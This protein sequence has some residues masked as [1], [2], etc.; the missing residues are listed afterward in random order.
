MKRSSPANR[1]TFKIETFKIQ[2]FREDA[3]LSQVVSVQMLK[4]G[5]AKTTTAYLLGLFAAQQGLKVLWVDL[6]QQ[7]NLTHACGVNADEKPVFV[8]VLEKK[9]SFEKAVVRLHENLSLFPSNLNN[10]IV[11]RVLLNS[12]RNWSVVVKQA[13]DG[14]RHQYDLIFIDTAP[15]LS[16]L[17]GAV[18]VAS[19][20]V[21][22]PVVPERYSILGAKKHLQDFTELARE[23]ELSN[24][25]K[26]L[27]SRY[28]G[29]ESYARDMFEL[30]EAT[31]R[32]NL[33]ESFIRQSSM[34]RSAQGLNPQFLLENTQ[35]A[36]AIA[37]D[38]TDVLQEILNL[39]PI[40]R[41]LMS[42]ETLL[43]A[44][45]KARLRTAASLSE[46]G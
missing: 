13:L 5:V 25:A 38:V 6:D 14:V 44:S 37:E 27:V 41:K 2:T 30:L 17:N 46:I 29:R 8:D 28:E 33:L 15:N 22:L 18:T 21:L 10:S 40:Q 11:D 35:R 3:D 39:L 1:E 23:F 16:A 45:I 7:G 32:Q 9:T 20:L 26:V 43:K 31:F 34:I 19:N 24:V 36:R 12:H 42:A 4:G